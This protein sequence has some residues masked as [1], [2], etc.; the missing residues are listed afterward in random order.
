MIQI[1]DKLIG[2]V[3]PEDASEFQII[4]EGTRVAYFLPSYK[5]FDIPFN[6][7]IVGTIKNDGTFDFDCEEYVGKTY[8]G[9]YYQ[10]LPP[11]MM[12]LA[13]MDSSFPYET[14]EESFI[15]LLNSKGILLEELNNEK[16][17]ILEK[18]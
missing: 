1:T 14:K 6:C 18:I 8:N 16:L 10:F 7:K 4:H 11:G 12:R 17:L 5:R 9:K 13:S 15:S 3:V 2:I